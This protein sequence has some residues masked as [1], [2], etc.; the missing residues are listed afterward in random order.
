[1]AKKPIKESPLA[2]HLRTSP[3]T[4]GARGGEPVPKGDIPMVGNQPG[5]TISQAQEVIDRLHQFL[6]GDPDRAAGPFFTV[7]QREGVGGIDPAITRSNWNDP[8]RS[9][10][11]GTMNTLPGQGLGG[12]FT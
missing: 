10:L 9:R 5:A 4:T 6:Y 2:E 12:G 1:M 3:W 8:F 11:G 7:T